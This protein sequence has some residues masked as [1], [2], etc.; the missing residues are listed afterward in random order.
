MR[1]HLDRNAEASTAIKREIQQQLDEEE[2]YERQAA[3]T[4]RTLASLKL[5]LVE[6]QVGLRARVGARAEG[7]VLGGLGLGLGFGL[8]FGLG[9]GLGSG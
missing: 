3:E 6:A 1:A 7:L 8:G 5:K 2:E 4:R 9:L